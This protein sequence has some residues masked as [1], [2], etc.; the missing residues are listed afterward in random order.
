M[1]GI[2]FCNPGVHLFLAPEK[3]LLYPKT[4]VPSSGGDCSFYM[5]PCL[6]PEILNPGF[7]LMVVR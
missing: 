7:A 3:A 4:F 5:K 6:R 1:Q 2:N